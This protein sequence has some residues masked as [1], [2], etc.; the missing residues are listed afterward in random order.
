MGTLSTA[1]TL[2]LFELLPPSIMPFRSGVDVNPADNCALA[3]G[4]FKSTLFF[5]NLAAA[6]RRV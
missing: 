3:L 2:K 4:V 5:C 1:A 6:L